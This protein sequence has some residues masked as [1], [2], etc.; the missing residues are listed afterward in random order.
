MSSRTGPTKLLGESARILPS[1]SGDGTY[2]V[3]HARLDRAYYVGSR[4]KAE[5]ARELLDAFFAIVEI[6][7]STKVPQSPRMVGGTHDMEA[8]D[9]DRTRR[10]GGGDSTS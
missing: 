5:R 10:G 7:G 1:A 2:L 4:E 9:G 3:M 6:P 8:D